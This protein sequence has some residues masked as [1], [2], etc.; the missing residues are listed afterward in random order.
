MQENLPTESTVDL[1]KEQLLALR[2]VP[3]LLPRRRGKKVNISTVYR[4]VQNGVRGK[5]LES[6]LLG[7][8]RYTSIEAIQRFL[9]TD[10]LALRE[11]RRTSSIDDQLDSANLK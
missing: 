1:C 8:I 3:D 4:W 2:D 11:R 10:T 6:M 5:T 7:G 9:S